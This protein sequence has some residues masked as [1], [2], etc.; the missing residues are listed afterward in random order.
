MKLSLL[1][2]SVCV[3]FT[4]FQLHAQNLSQGLDAHY[5]FD[6]NLED[7]TVNNNDLALYS[8]TISYSTVTSGDECLNLNGLSRVRSVNVY[9]NTTYT[10]I[11]ISL[12][13]KASST[14]N[15][16]Q[17]ICQG[18]EMGFGIYIQANTGK[19]LG[20]VDGS[21]SN[22]YV[23][24]T[25]VVNNE[26]HHVVVQSNGTTTFM[27]LDGVLD[28]SLQEPLSVGNGDTD[29]RLFF[30]RS[31]LNA[32]PFTG[33]INEC[34]I[35][36]R[37]LDVCEIHEL[38]GGS[39]SQP[40]AHF[41]FENSL[42]DVSGNNNDF[43]SSGTPVTYIGSG[44]NTGNAISFNGNNVLSSAN[45]FDNSSYSELSV[46]VWLKTTTINSV[47]QNVVQGAFLG[48]GLYM[49]ANTGKIIGFADGSVAG[50]YVSSIS[51]ADGVWH[52]IVLRSNGSTTSM[53]IDGIYDG[54]ITE[55]LLVG[56][57]ASN[58]RIFLGKTNQGV[59]P[60]TGLMDE[61]M[62][63]DRALSDCEIKEL[64]SDN[65]NANIPQL[66]SQAIPI[67]AY[68]NPSNGNFHIEMG[69]PYQDVNILVT[70]MNGKTI[71]QQS[72]NNAQLLNI[73]IDAG[74]G[75]YFIQV[76]SADKQGFVKIVKY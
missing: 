64:S 62:I 66:E 56:N 76:K 65:V 58:N 1:F 17:I 33:S 63:F 3:F 35:Y 43:V 6:N 75:I 47:F 48:F 70:D 32:Y 21:S 24:S 60:F 53:Y 22:S 20:F 13:F 10:E 4:T 36:R 31:N 73:N 23:S 68:P 7:E 46:S 41:S 72:Y 5:K 16:L 74:A 25:S 55:N 67:S 26:W 14:T 18:A 8:G 69:N 29:N 61:L 38:Y 19:L 11:A 42:D 51:V 49:E 40:K 37:M 54:S 28:G 34:R 50:G 9:N 57:G 45:P 44:N 59:Y 27:Y 12:W 30:G 2:L 71:Q 15:D 52:H 39:T